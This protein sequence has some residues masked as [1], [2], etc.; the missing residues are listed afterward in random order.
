LVSINGAVY[1]VNAL[2]PRK[3]SRNPLTV[4]S[5]FASWITIE[6]AWVHL[7]WQ[8]VV[9]A[10]FIGKGALRTRR[11]RLAL[12]VNLASWVG[13]GVLVRQSVSARHEIRKAFAG[14]DLDH[15]GFRGL[16]IRR[17]RD[18]PYTRAGARTLRL[19]VSE[20]R[21]PTP[22]DARRPAILQI[23]GG[24]WVIGDKREQGLPLLKELASRGWVGFNANYRLAPFATFPDQLVDL[25]HAVA[26]IREH[27]EEYRVDPDFIVVTGGSAGGHLAALM[28]L[29]ADDP[30]Y[31]PGF[32]DA[33]TSFQAAVPFYG[34]YDFTNRAGH[35][36]SDMV[37]QFIGPWVMKASF[38]DDPE[39]FADASPIDQVHP[40]APPFLVVHGVQ[41]SLVPVAT[42]RE[43]VS[44]LR[45]VSTS[46]VLY[47]ELPGA[48]HAFEILP[49]IRANQVVG[50][51][52]DWLD[53]V[54]GSYVIEV[55]KRAD[56]AAAR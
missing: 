7:V 26:W 23:H 32:E 6:L 54:W 47:L 44:A 38:D 37:H 15:E 31:Q 12:L 51:V 2:R 21:L 16:G 35:W 46:P 29:T 43:F 49:S 19:D 27:A 39:R 53:T 40:G 30:R 42:A 50:A 52:A 28:A 4:W 56:D 9:S 3:L 36:T 45:D 17:T 20:P 11:G 55:A 33:D 41:D 34:V 14:V 18:V 48:Q 1:T 10:I 22:P 8:V 5:F 13:L 25:K 24:G